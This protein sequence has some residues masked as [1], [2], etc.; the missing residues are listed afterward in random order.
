MIDFTLTEHDQAQLDRTRE[1]AL[2]C[3]KYARQYDENEGEFPPD[4]L[5]EAAEFYAN[6]APLPERS[7]ADTSQPVMMALQAI[8]QFWGD[9]SVRLRRSGGG[10]LGRVL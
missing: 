10:G 3:R 5:P 4:E 1:A 6:Q 7:E 9:Y 8:G 2:I